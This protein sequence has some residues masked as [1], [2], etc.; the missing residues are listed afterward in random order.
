MK[1]AFFTF[2][3]AC[4]F[5]FLTATNVQAQMNNRPFSFNTPSGGVGMSIGGQQAILNKQVFGVE[6]ENMVRGPSGDLL[7]V[8]KGDGGVA[9]VSFEGGSFIPSFRGSSFRGENESWAAGVFNSFFEPTNRDSGL[10]SYAKFQTGAAI[11][12]WTG[13]VSSGTPV[14]FMPQ[15]PV[16]IWTGMVVQAAY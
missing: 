10:S 9:I 8:T 6:P 2:I 13:R 16:D 3:A 4:A 15:S 7:S 5:L 12:T 1:I 11:S 14:S